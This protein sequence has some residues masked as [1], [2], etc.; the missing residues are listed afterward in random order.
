MTYKSVDRILAATRAAPGGDKIDTLNVDKA[1]LSKDIESVNTI[2]LWAKSLGPSNLQ[3]RDR[4]RSKIA[5][6]AG[7]LRDL[8]KADRDDDG[9]V[10][11]FYPL[12]LSDY[13]DV[14]SGIVL[15]A[16]RAME[17][18]VPL[19]NGDPR[20]FER[21][22]EML[23]DALRSGSPQSSGRSQHRSNGRT[24]GQEGSRWRIARGLS[25]AGCRR[26]TL[27]N[28]ALWRGYTTSKLSN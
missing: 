26:Q 14:T 23:R 20:E 1:D 6:K 25:I 17:P 22:D 18:L 21:A 16:E 4:R 13:L 3:E 28:A 19:I 24:D 15:A 27:R 11:M 8:L 12:T 7:E 10:G 2:R 5:K 9:P